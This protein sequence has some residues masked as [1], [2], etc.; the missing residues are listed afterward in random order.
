MNSQNIKESCEYDVSLI[1]IS[2]SNT[3]VLVESLNTGHNHVRV[4]SNLRSFSFDILGII[5]H[6]KLASHSFIATICENEIANSVCG[7]LSFITIRNK[8]PIML[9]Y[10]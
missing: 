2:L 8:K 10:I 7:M 5:H 1:N 9:V 4:A 3:E 6:L